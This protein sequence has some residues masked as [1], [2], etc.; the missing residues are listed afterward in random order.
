MKKKGFY[1]FVLLTTLAALLLS[2]GD[3]KTYTPKPKGYMRIELPMQ[4]YYRV[5]SLSSDTNSPAGPKV[6]LPFSFEANENSVIMLK[7]NNM[8]LKWV[9]LKYPDV[10]GIIFLTYIPL[11]KPSDLEG[12]VDTSYQLLSKHFDFSSGVNERAFVNKD[13]HVYATTY[14]LQGQNVAST[15]QFWA[16]D[17]IHH[18]LRGSLY[19][20]CVPNNDSL[21]PVL[22]YLQ[23]DI[24][25]ILE[26]LRWR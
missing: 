13:E 19:I 5:D 4:K 21:A 14:M 23:Q 26:T 22:K 10:N 17:S 8:R 20:D 15:Y 2:C 7:R 6:A 16:T 18:F 24:D 3:G 12:E 1:S 11:K 9:D 25:H